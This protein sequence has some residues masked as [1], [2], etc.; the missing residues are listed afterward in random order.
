MKN[1]F[2][3]KLHVITIG[4]LLTNLSAL[5]AQDVIFLRSGEEISSNVTEVNPNEIKYKKTDNPDGPVYTALKTDVLLIK[6]KNGTKDIVAN[7]TGKGSKSY[8]VKGAEYS[9]FIESGTTELGG[10]ISWA[11]ESAPN[12]NTTIS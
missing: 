3:I 5:K 8:Y 11:S 10:D 4:F 12:S 9:N 2:K 7:E 6:Y 1:F